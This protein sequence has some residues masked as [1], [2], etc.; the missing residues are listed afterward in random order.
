V[1]WHTIVG[2][3]SREKTG[4]PSQKPLGIMRRIIQASS[5]PGDTVLDFFAGSG[6]T[7]AACLEL[8][9]KFVLVDE[10]PQAIKVMKNRFQGQPVKFERPR[11][12]PPA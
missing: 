9:R 6:S 12:K 8:G 2:T 3:A 5:L 1:W 10:N 11:P 4:Y 7:G